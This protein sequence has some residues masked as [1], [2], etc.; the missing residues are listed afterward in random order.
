MASVV[1]RAA[2]HVHACPSPTTADSVSPDLLACSSPGP[3]YYM[4]PPQKTAV[5]SS[6]KPVMQLMMVPSVNLSDPP[7]SMSVSPRESSS[8]VL[9]P[10]TSTLSLSS[11]GSSSDHCTS[12]SPCLLFLSPT[13][14]PSPFSS[15]CVL[16]GSVV[17]T[18]LSL[19]V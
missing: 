10:S 7:F 2:S 14:C 8:T 13:C 12:L 4:C 17:E 15:F 3:S 18:V 1:V 6:P 9:V 19:G 5:S 16:R 11:G